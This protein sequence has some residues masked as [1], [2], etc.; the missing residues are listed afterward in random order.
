MHMLFAMASRVVLVAMA[1]VLANAVQAQDKRV[2]LVIG[3]DR[4]A[5][6]PLVNAARDGREVALALRRLGFEVIEVIDGSKAQTEAGIER[7]QAALRGRQGVGLFYY[8][9]HAVQIEWRNFMV[10]VD[11][12]LKTPRDVS[13]Q[14][15]DISK[16]LD[17]F[18]AAGT[19]TN[20]VVLDACRDNPFGSTGRAAGLA[21]LDAPPRT[22]IAFSTAPGNVADD[23]LEGGHS[24]YT[25]YLLQELGRPKSRIEDVFKRVR[26]QVRQRTEGRQIPWENTSLEEEFFFDQSGSTAAKDVDEEQRRREIEAA[27]EKEKA[28]WDKVAKSTNPQ[29]LYAFMKQYPSGAVYEL[30]Q[31][32]LD[33]VQRPSL[34]LSVPPAGVQVLPSGVN[35]YEVGDVLTYERH[36]LLTNERRPVTLTVTYADKDRVE[37]NHGQAVRDQ[38]GGV[39]RNRFGEKSPASMSAPADIAIGKRWRSA[40]INTLPNGK[41]SS[42]HWDNH[43]AAL[44]DI[45][46]PA[47]TFRA[48]RIDRQ[49]WARFA[50][51]SATR[52]TGTTWVDPRT[53]Q[54]VRIDLTFTKD[55]KAVENSSDR[56]V[57]LQQVARK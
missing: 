10:P 52:M 33:Q 25:H 56:L 55:G 49:G 21:Q 39:L 48:Y 26:L 11:A 19:R 45:E 22:F 36:D 2:A 14:T 38:M 57:R 5:A 27:F 17:A 43:V 12:A 4:Y 20:I 29:D 40:F 42:N 16:V 18:A 53:M 50:G 41:V 46:V 8:A 3:N 7:M 54:V 15:V 47:G 31:F 23:G 24:L 37:L 28:D 6:Q 34:R 32:R 44:E 35:R 1:L 9:G 51:G 13:A 30:A